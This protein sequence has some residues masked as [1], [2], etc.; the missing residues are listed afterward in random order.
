MK[1]SLSVVIVL[2]A[3]TGTVSAQEGSFHLDKEFKMNANGTVKL[4]ASDA[5]IYITGSSRATAHVKIDREIT[6]KGLTFGHEEFSV[7]VAENDGDL[8][9]QEHSSSVSVGMVGYRYEKYTINIEAPQGSSLIIRGD[10]GDLWIKNIDGSISLDLDDADVELTG[11]SGN[12]FDFRMDDGEI[13]MDEA[14]GSLDLSADDTDVTIRNAN[15]TH[16]DANLDD[17]DLVIETSLDDNGDYLIDAQDGMVS[18]SITKGG[19][20]F[21]IRHDDG[22]V[23]TEGDFKTIEDSENRTRMTLA[24]GNAKVNIRTDDARVKLIQR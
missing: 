10:D 7:D 9:I 2:L 24:S 21:E 20:R 8:N 1:A 12:K 23:S 14:K 18:M 5:K 19:G 4:R 17:G 3:V 13:T 6:T 22:R 15:F 16:I 11:C